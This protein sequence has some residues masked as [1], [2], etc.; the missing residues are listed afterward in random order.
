MGL[1]S[2]SSAFIMATTQSDSAENAFATFSYAGFM[3]CEVSVHRKQYKARLYLAVSTL[4]GVSHILVRP[5]ELTQGAVKATKTF[6]FSSKAI[7]PKFPES[8]SRY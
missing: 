5:N 6:L 1:F 3:F 4:Y 8:S 2:A 7:S